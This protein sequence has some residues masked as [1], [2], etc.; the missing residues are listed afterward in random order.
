MN[1]IKLL[2]GLTI[3]FLV[4]S[5]V[6]YKAVDWK[7]KDDYTIRIYHQ[8]DHFVS[9]SGLKASILFDEENV[10]KSK[11]SASIVADSINCG[12]NN[13]MKE[14]S[15]KPET[16]DVKNFPLISFQSTSITKKD[17]AALYFFRKT[18]FETDDPIK[19][20]YQAI[21]NLTIKGV[22]K[23]IKIPFTFENEIFKGC[24]AI[25]PKDFNIT[26]EMF[27]EDLNVLLTIPVTK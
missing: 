23:E 4:T 21:G 7:V 15:K 18:L 27:Q 25:H 22:T 5:F 17:S 3:T 1:K 20:R 12:R 6:V 10:E 19:F 8:G 24:F 14:G 11:I 16:L 2:I 9:F 26:N 13:A